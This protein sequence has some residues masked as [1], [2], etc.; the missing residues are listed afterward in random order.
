MVDQ[1]VVA[2]IGLVLL[3][4]SVLTTY[5]SLRVVDDGEFEAYFVRGEMQAV[6]RPGVNMVLPF[7]SKTY[8]IDPQTMQIERGSERIDVPTEFRDEVQTDPE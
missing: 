1:L 3:L 4:L 2:A 8:P 5:S 6:L 7:V